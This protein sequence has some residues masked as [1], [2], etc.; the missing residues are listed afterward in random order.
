MFWLFSAVFLCFS[1]VFWGSEGLKNP[2]CFGVVFLGF[3]LN[4]KEKKIRA[5]HTVNYLN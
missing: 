3:Y 5:E 1:R 4:T 2:W